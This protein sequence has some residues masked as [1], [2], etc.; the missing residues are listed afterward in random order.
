MAKHNSEKRTPFRRWIP[1]PEAGRCER[2][3]KTAT[4]V[5]VSI[6]LTLL[7][8]TAIVSA[9]DGVIEINA[10]C[11]PTGCMAGDQPGY[12]VEITSAGSYVLTSNL[13]VADVDV[14][15]V[16]IEAP[17][18]MLDLN[19]FAIQGPVSC[20]G[21][22]VTSC[23]PSGSGIGISGGRDGSIHGGSVSGF[24]GRGIDTGSARIWNIHASENGGDGI[25][26]FD[27]IVRDSTVK[28]NGDA[29]ISGPFQTGDLQ[30]Q[31]V[32]IFG[33]AGD[34]VEITKGTVLNSNI[35]RNGGRGIN[36]AFTGDTGS[37]YGFN[38]LNGNTEGPTFGVSAVLG[39]NVVNGS[40]VCPP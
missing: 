28:R 29:G 22:P 9:K 23:S 15:G 5:R 6:A 19:G 16:S 8:V 18:V 37:G 20:V 13:A 40:A 34:G 24:G 21:T 17:K 35:T 26:G 2:D 32:Q 25:R 11:V 31:R 27:L 36:G 39:C 14:D 33:N 38:S 10:A 4:M 7:F 1:S 30:V 3:L 12:P